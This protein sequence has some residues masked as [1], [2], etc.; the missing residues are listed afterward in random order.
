MRVPRQFARWAKLRLAITAPPPGS[1]GKRLV[2][3]Q[4]HDW[5]RLFLLMDGFLG[6]LEKDSSLFFSNFIK[7]VL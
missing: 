3:L 7:R 6:T 4:R 5:L 2:S 1:G